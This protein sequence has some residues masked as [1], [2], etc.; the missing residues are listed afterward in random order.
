MNRW[1]EYE[2]QFVRDNVDRLT[3]EQMSDSLHRSIDS[4][5]LFIHRNRIVVGETVKR[6][7]VLELLRLRYAHTEDFTPSSHFYRETGITP[8]RWWKLYKGK[9]QVSE[10]DYLAI[11]K[12]LNISLEEAFN[13]RQLSFFDA[14][15]GGITKE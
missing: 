5:K 2:K 4:V 1:S 6:N 12:Y 9:L 3:V 15:G 8:Q 11:T 13:C 10:S 14:G 7:I